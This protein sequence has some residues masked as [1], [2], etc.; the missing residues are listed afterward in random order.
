MKNNY[1]N[2]EDQ[3]EQWIAAAESIKE[4]FGLEKALGYLNRREILKETTR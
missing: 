3:L 1:F 4:K 2:N